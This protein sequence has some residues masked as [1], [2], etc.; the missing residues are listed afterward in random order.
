MSWKRGPLAALA[1][2]ALLLPAT[3]CGTGGTH[4][5]G[6][7]HS[8]AP[9]GRLLDETDEEGRHYRQVGKDD[10]PGVGIE[11]AP[12][13]TGGWEV[14]LTV[15]SF[16]FTAAGG[17]AAART[18]QGMARLYVDGGPVTWLRTATYHLDAALV[19]HGT[20]HVTARLYADDGTVWAVHG[21]PVEST[22]DITASGNETQSPPVSSPG[23][24]GGEGGDGVDG[25]D[26]A[27]VDGGVRDGGAEQGGV[28]D[29]G[30]VGG[31]VAY[32]GVL[33]EG[34]FREGVSRDDVPREGGRREG[35]LPDR[36]SRD[37]GAAVRPPGR[38]AGRTE[39]KGR[40]G[41]GTCGGGA[42]VLSGTGV[43]L[44]TLGRGTPDPVRKAS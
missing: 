28:P 31:G 37:G 7:E 14:R 6:E 26:G 3:G 36:A 42:S 17:G 21:R 33:R 27:A 5:G 40:F 30:Q 23:G 19:P 35:V 29:D 39:V 11:V 9:A 18:G 38:G 1:A 15:R 41:Q 2:C 16:R 8:P 43:R 25:E 32:G 4:R 34:A 12:G 44:R 13:T 22:A 10:A 24:E 20:H